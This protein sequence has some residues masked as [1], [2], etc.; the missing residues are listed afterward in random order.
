M[1]TGASVT[2]KRFVVSLSA[3]VAR[4]Q[5]DNSQC[6]VPGS[7]PTPRTPRRPS[8]LL[9]AIARHNG[10]TH[11][12]AHDAPPQWCELLFQRRHGHRIPTA[13]AGLVIA[14]MQVG[15]DG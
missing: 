9:D 14:H 5:P 4:T 8:R 10:A 15:R 3:S 12:L 1:I 13:N 7:R 6:A 11:F 2:G